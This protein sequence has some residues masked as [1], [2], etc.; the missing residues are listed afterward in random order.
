MA[1]WDTTEFTEAD[2]ADL[3]FVARGSS[4]PIYRATQV[5]LD[6]TVVVKVI[7]TADAPA[8]A[9]REARLM[10]R[11]SWHSHVLSLHG[12]TTLRDGS[13]A[14]VME[15]AAGG[16]LADVVERDGPLAPE[17][18]IALARQVTSA[19]AAAHRLGVVHGDIKPSNVLFADD[20]T[21]R[22]SDFG[23]AGTG[24]D[25]LDTIE[26]SLAFA[27]PE[28]FDGAR[29]SPAQDV[30]SIAV[31]LHVAAVGR[32]PFGSDHLPAAAVMAR[33]Q[34][35]RLRFPA[36]VAA[37][38][39]ALLEILD[40]CLDPDPEA[41]PTAEML[42]AA[43]GDVAAPDRAP[44]DDRPA[45]S[46]VRRIAMAALVLVG[47]IGSMVAVDRWGRDEEAAASSGLCSAYRG[48]LVARESLFAGL[49]RDLERATS[50]V[51][52]VER[53]L[54]RYPREWAAQVATYLVAASSA[55]GRPLS[56][57]ES[58]LRLLSSAGVLRTLGGGKP[59]L[60]DGESGEFDP[61]AA[62]GELRD[63]ARVFSEANQLGADRCSF[64]ATELTAA[65]ARMNAAIYA[66]LAN[67][68]FMDGFFSD[69]RSLQV[70]DEDVVLLMA[71]MARPFF[72]ALLTGHWDW[73]LELLE[74]RPQ[75]RSALSLEYPD[76]VVTALA[77]EPELAAAALDDEW[78]QDLVTGWGRVGSATRQGVQARHPELV[79]LIGLE[80]S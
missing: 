51:E 42:L 21:I 13:P 7:D 50:P 73:F 4:G 9:R 71:S 38:S 23:I 80:P 14:L 79:G 30:Y 56:A 74:Q 44:L 3:E 54:V 69:P 12:V 33:I 49:S 22:L 5:T 35:E 24:T 1:V 55:T 58:Q 6:R 29:P 15:Y 46:G 19:V 16:S 59:Y 45:A 31:T 64:D 20:S 10:G 68:E 17:R 78:R 61:I 47:V 8:R 63:P 34:S 66:N 37:D 57:T 72:E 60:F 32:Q 48:S 75:I 40:R 18:V 53:L 52:A 67:P 11:L 65:K 27:P 36:A 76:L 2:L 77:A 62:P 70:L 25:T 41:R 26:G 39:S 43:L 28:L